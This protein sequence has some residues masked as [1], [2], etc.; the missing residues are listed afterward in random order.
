M[1]RNR[2]RSEAKRTVEFLILVAIVGWLAV[3]AFMLFERVEAEETPSSG[4][5]VQRSADLFPT[6]ITA[7]NTSAPTPRP[8]ETTPPQIVSDA[9]GQPAPS[10]VDAAPDTATA[11]STPTLTSTP[12]ETPTETPT[13]TPTMTPT[14]T[15]TPTET[16]TPVPMRGVYPATS[17]PALPEELNLGIIPTPVPLVK[18]PTGTINIV[19]LGSD[20]RPDETSWRTPANGDHVV[21]TSGSVDLYT[22]LDISAH[23]SS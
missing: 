3:I 8:N 16:T 5:P 17:T 18:V 19:L 21:H 2:P 6:K 1:D 12:T 14:E 22:Q 10:P 4:A 7:K 20:K 23:Q 9:D 15:P 11:T 13:L